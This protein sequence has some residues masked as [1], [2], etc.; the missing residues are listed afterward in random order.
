MKVEKNI[1][2]SEFIVNM[3]DPHYGQDNSHVDI[4]AKTKTQ[5]ESLSQFHVPYYVLTNSE[6]QESDTGAH[7]VHM[8]LFSHYPNL[9]LYFHRILMAFEFLQKHPEIEKAALTDAGDV[10]M[11]NYPF[12]KV[13]EGILYMGDESFYIFATPVITWHEDLQCIEDFIRENG[14]LPTLNL[15]VMVGTRAVLI[16]YLGIMV[17]IIT[18]AQLKI[19]Q[20]GD[21]YQLSDVEMAISNYVA[22]KYFGERL[23]HGREVTT[24]MDGY[25]EPSSAWFKHK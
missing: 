18:D 17:K 25:Q 19:S 22:Y 6:S 12:D 20:G 13:E 7:I 3:Y 4:P 23:I 16:E 11:L 8:D 10:T 9:T 1:V 5:A 21:A 2:I 15:G 24:I 14:L